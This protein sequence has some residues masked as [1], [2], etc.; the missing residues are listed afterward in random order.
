MDPTGLTLVEL[1]AAYRER[2]LRPSDALETWLERIEVGPIY[3]VVTAGRARR[4]AVRADALF[5]A[6]VDRGPLQGVP[7][8][9]KDLMDTE[10]DVTAAGSAVLAEGPAARR[11]CPAAARLDRAGAL[12]LGKTNM[13][14]LA[15]SGLGLNPHFGTPGCALDPERVPGGSSSGSAVAVATGLACVA[16]GSDTG[17]SVRIPAAFNGIVGLKTTDGA[18]P[19][20]GC[21]PLSPTLDTLGPLARTV[22]DTWHA[23]RALADLPPAPFPGPPDGPLS[24][25]VPES[26]AAGL[27]P[28]VLHAFEDAS[29]RLAAAGHR[30]ERREVPVLDRVADVYARHGTFAGIE[31]FA[32]HRELLERGGGR[33]DPR[34]SSRVLAYGTRTGDDLARLVEVRERIRREMD[35][36][37]RPYDA[38]LAPTVPILPPRIAD[39]GSDQAYL[40]ANASVLRNTQIF[41]FLGW[42]AASVPCERTAGGLSV[43]LMVAAGP[44]EEERVFRICAEVE[45][46]PGQAGWAREPRGGQPPARSA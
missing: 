23:W 42:P 31:G 26:L 15:F 25:L 1:A 29:H 45:G 17:G 22:A 4:Q 10:G 11:D 43:G 32:L 33:I 44:S 13:T 37:S 18:I 2:R 6:G 30:I 14:E 9:L 3:R 19:T 28:E 7:I 21:V 5:E 35:A 20:A 39:L 16:L 40:E 46:A 24:L 27:E 8:A 36:I 34:V 41:N 38:V 12:F